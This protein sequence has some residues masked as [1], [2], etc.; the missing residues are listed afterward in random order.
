MTGQEGIAYAG[1]A[2]MAIQTAILIGLWRGRQEAADKA[3]AAAIANTETVF[4]LRL[5]N[6]ETK[7]GAQADKLDMRIKIVDGDINAL[8]Q[9]IA[10]VKERLTAS[11]TERREEFQRLHKIGNDT[12]AL[13]VQHLT[14]LQ[15]SYIPRAE[16]EARHDDVERRVSRLEQKS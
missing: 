14:K 5:T 10:D 11:E 12:H 3:A 16:Y 1:F 6:L 13:I 4:G 8:K 7:V 15:E 9:S 2:W